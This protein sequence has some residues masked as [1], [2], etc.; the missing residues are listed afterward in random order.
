MSEQRPRRIV[1]RTELSERIGLKR[2]AIAD[3]VKNDPTFPKPV[4]ITSRAIGWFEDELD[5]WFENL[6]GRREEKAGVEGHSDPVLVAPR[7]D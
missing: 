6:A 2:T 1:R 5:G 7:S 3:L 4:R